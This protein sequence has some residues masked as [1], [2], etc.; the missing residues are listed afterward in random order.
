MKAVEKAHERTGGREKGGGGLLP[1][2]SNGPQNGGTV[3]ADEVRKKSQDSRVKRRG[4]R[5]QEKSFA[6]RSLLCAIG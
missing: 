2:E 1:Y 5:D 4:L 6:L 3:D